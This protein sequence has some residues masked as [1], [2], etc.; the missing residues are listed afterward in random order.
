MIDFGALCFRV[1]REYVSANIERRLRAMS[2]NTYLLSIYFGEIGYSVSSVAF[3]QTRRVIKRI[4]RARRQDD[5]GCANIPWDVG[6]H[7][8][9]SPEITV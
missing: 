7:V 1:P 5:F 6:K 8:P 4:R 9:R 3:S 2:L